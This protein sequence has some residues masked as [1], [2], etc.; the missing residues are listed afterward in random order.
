MIL[1]FASAF[2][3]LLGLTVACQAQADPMGIYDVTVGETFDDMEVSANFAQ[4]SSRIFPGVGG[5]SFMEHGWATVIEDLSVTAPDGA[6]I[7]RSLEYLAEYGAWYWQLTQGGEPYTGPVALHYR[8]NLHYA[9]ERHPYGNE[10]GGQYFTSSLYTVARPVFISSDI[11]GEWE[12][13]FHLPEGMEIAY[14]VQR[15]DGAGPVF[16]AHSFEELQ[17]NPLTVGTFFRETKDLD[18]AE[19]ELVLPAL[20]GQ[21]GTGVARIAEDLMSLYGEI[22]PASTPGR[23]ELVL[24]PSYA[25]DGE[26]Y[27]NASVVTT[28]ATFSDDQRLVW[29]GLLAHEMFHY[30][31]GVQ[32]SSSEPESTQWFTEGFT[33]YY[34]VLAQA[35][36]GLI[37]RNQFQ[38]RLEQNMGNYQF[39]LQNDGFEDL[40]LREAGA[41]KTR[42]RM[43][44]YNG[45]FVI[46][47]ALD[48]QIHTD[49][50]GEK[51]LDDVMRLLFDRFARTN[52]HYTL[53]D[54]V[55]AVSE[56]A[57][58]DYTAF[59]QDHVY[60]R[61]PVDAAALFD[62]LG[63]DA[64]VISYAGETYIDPEDRPTRAQR[65][66]WTWLSRNRF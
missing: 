59:F 21:E 46:A 43:G 23:Y 25:N 53:D 48:V 40:S 49:T 31:N 19:L 3:I 61:Q 58:R 57:G 62:A 15:I 63:F 41:D 14:P 38:R 29:S 22:M 30:W 16:L 47:L 8:V 33:E 65:Q 6:E 66:A 18:G 54:V 64:L 17:D 24:F 20:H 55:A 44:V 45:G 32:L 56:V 34:A 35:H 11:E 27:L 7:D 60:G 37:S 36:L 9:R 5:G 1:R 42:N 10:Q 50:D 52:S 2:F 4:T 26:S 51:S 13:R 28:E 12:A 39:F